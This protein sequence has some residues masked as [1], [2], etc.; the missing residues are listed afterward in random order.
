MKPL[1][2]IQFEDERVI[3]IDKYSGKKVF[4]GSIKD[5]FKF[6]RAKYG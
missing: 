3:M 4:K 6:L 2:K 5:F 1:N